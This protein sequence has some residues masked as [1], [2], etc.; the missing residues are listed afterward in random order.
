MVGLKGPGRESE[1]RARINDDNMV[2]CCFVPN[3][4][5]TTLE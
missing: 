3:G 4:A 1:L 2:V 5:G